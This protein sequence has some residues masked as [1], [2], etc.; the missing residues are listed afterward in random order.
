MKISETWALVCEKASRGNV[1]PV[2][3]T[4]FTAGVRAAAVE[5]LM[6]SR[7]VLDDEASSRL[8]ARLMAAADRVDR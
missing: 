3:R 5:L 2:V 4:S 1:Q 8:Y 7:D 6:H